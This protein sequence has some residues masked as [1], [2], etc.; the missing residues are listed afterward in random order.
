[1][2]GFLP[3]FFLLVVLKIPVLGALW[4][5]WW[6][7]KAPETESSQDD[8]SGGP[9]R[10]RPHP[11][12]RGPQHHPDGAGAVRRGRGVPPAQRRPVFR[13]TRDPRTA[14]TSAGE[15]PSKREGHPVPS[16][17]TPASGR[18]TPSPPLNQP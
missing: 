13:P 12:P 17:P 6:A 8:S 3:I 5:I 7:A 9:T 15:K 1:M 14:S 18:D 10:W 16:P 2:E 4:L 11:R